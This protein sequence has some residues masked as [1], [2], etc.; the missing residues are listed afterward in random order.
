M[1]RGIA[2]VSVILL[3]VAGLWAQNTVS[4]YTTL[5]EPL[6]KALFETFQTETG[7]TVNFVRL[8]GGE[9]VAR[10]E[11]ESAN[12]QASIWVG[13][14]GLDHITA[15]SKGLTTPYKSRAAANTDAQY[16]DPQDYWIGLYVGPL[17]FVTNLDRAKELGITPP[18]SW[19]DLLK[20]EYKGR[21]R[22]ANP[23]TSGTA[24][25]V[26]TTIRYVMG[27]DEQKTFDY[28]KKLDANIDQYTKS[29]SAPGKSVAIGEVPVGIGYAHDQV[30][31]KAE[32]A[33]VLITAPSDGSG[34]ELASMSLIKGGK[35]AVNAKKLYDWV[36]TSKKAQELFTQWYLVLVAKG[37]PR[38]PS[39]LSLTEIRTVKQD[40]AWDGD[41]VNKDR[42]LKRWNDEIGSL[43]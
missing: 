3:A 31:L 36:L 26:I 23:N 32:G 4:A 29:G 40:M 30:K 12:P 10:M 34:Y 42:L 24:Y 11:A 22:M 20:P 2:F 37:S 21:I 18:K 15:K 8:S 38:H 16:R 43:R 17:T 7:I 9:A 25:N 27:G 33:N 35:D 19:A 13:G 41:K 1:K 28:L 39:A 14:V 5:E 6:A